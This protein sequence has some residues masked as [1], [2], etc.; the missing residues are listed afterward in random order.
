MTSQIF[1]NRIPSE[2]LFDLLE[3]I[4]IKNNG[5]YLLN[6]GAYKKAMYNSLIEPFCD[7]I[8][9]YYHIS[10]KFYVTRKQNQSSFI[11]IL[12]QICKYLNINYTS[13]ITYNKSTYDI[14]YQIYY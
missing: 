3:K 7:T 5:Y 8:L 9:P 2:I 13:K 14:I 6:R 4:C 10:K 12:R 1:K 11:T